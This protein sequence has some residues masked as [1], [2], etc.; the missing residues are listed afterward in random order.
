GMRARRAALRLSAPAPLASTRSSCSPCSRPKCGLLSRRKRGD[1]STLT[2][3]LA[4]VS[5]YELF[6]RGA[7]SLSP[8]RERNRLQ[9]NDDARNLVRRE[10]FGAETAHIDGVKR[11]AGWHDARDDLLS[12]LR[13]R[14]RQHAH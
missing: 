3:L 10:P 7:I 11:R 13:V 8:G 14:R 1:Y 4:H 9:K 2:E 6:K 12:P 5:A